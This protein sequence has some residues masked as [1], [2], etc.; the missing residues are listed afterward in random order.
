[1]LVLGLSFV[2]PLLKILR[3]KTTIMMP[4]VFVL[5]MVGTYAIAGRKFDILVMIGFGILGFAMRKLG[6][7]EAPLVLGIILG[8]MVDENLRRGLILSDG[9][10]LPFFSSTI[11]IILI[12]AV[13]FT[14]FGRLKPVK[15]VT[16]FLLW[17]INAL[18][19]VLLRKKQ[20]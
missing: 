20:A 17:P 10:L 9:S 13:F 11:S 14:L 1:M 15:K 8:P 6:Y 12:I 4:V 5:C 2:K 3:M 7:P 19:G 18:Y 16:T